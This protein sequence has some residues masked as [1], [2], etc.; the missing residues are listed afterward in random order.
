MLGHCQD[1]GVLSAARDQERH[2]AQGG[3]MPM[4]AGAHLVD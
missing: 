4:W 1:F 2:E 3:F